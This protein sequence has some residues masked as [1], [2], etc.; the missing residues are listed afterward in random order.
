MLPR[1]YEP[2]YMDC[3]G[4]SKTVSDWVDGEKL[5]MTDCCEILQSAV[6]FIQVAEIDKEPIFLVIKSRPNANEELNIF[7]SS[8]ASMGSIQNGKE[9]IPVAGE[10]LF[11]QGRDLNITEEEMKNQHERLGMPIMEAIKAFV[12]TPEGNKAI[13]DAPNLEHIFDAQSGGLSDLLLEDK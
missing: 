1:T 13:L 9:P 10:C 8:V 7:A 3:E 12:D 5:T 2:K 4:N 11:L 6:T